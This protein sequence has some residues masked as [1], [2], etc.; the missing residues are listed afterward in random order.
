LDRIHLAGKEQLL[1]LA[2]FY[3][4][5]RYEDMNMEML[6]EALEEVKSLFSIVSWLE[7]LPN[8]ELAEFKAEFDEQGEIAQIAQNLLNKGWRLTHHGTLAKL[9][10]F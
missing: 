7:T 2:E 1:L 5:E 8:Q 6:M 3:D 9:V 4:V 10:R